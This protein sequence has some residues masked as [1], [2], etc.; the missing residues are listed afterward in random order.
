MKLKFGYIKVRFRG[1]VKSYSAAAY[2]VCAVELVDGTAA[3]ANKEG[4]LLRLHDGILPL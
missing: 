1:M 2:A 4:G 3:V